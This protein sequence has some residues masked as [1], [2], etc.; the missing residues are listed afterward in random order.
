LLPGLKAIWPA[1]SAVIWPQARR[2][3][4][5]VSSGTELISCDTSSNK[6]GAKKVFGCASLNEKTKITGPSRYGTAEIRAKHAAGE[7]PGFGLEQAL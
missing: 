3:W 1:W 2:S 5:Q 7:W 4:D 6:D